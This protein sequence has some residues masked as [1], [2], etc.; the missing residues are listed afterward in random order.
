MYLL[1]I[2]DD[3]KSELVKTEQYLKTWQKNHRD[4]DLKIECFEYAQELLL[5]VKDQQ[6]TPDLLLMDIYMPGRTGI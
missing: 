4:Y 3:D 6:Y 2:C 5:R 1:A